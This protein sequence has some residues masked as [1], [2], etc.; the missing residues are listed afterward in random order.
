[1]KVINQTRWNTADLRRFVKRVAEKELVPRYRRQVV[2]TFKSL[3][4]NGSCKAS[5]NKLGRFQ[6]S[7]PVVSVE[8]QTLCRVMA[9]CMGYMK[10]LTM[11]EMRRS[12]H[13]SEFGN[14]REIYEWAN[15]LPLGTMP[16]E[17]TEPTQTLAQHLAHSH[18]M[19]AEWDGKVRRAQTAFK[20]WHRR[21]RLQEAHLK[22]LREG[23]P[24]GPFRVRMKNVIEAH[25]KGAGA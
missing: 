17:K 7:I 9:W 8:R 18:R 6:I 4:G 25:D 12:P 15:R 23:T 24:T 14:W 5:A 16:E 13:Y 20:K 2:V 10:D 21:A 1:M 19:M 3:R 11:A 22:R